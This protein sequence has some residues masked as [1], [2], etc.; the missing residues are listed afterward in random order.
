MPNERDDRVIHAKEQF[1]MSHA[2]LCTIPL[3]LSAGDAAVAAA[4]TERCVPDTHG[5]EFTHSDINACCRPDRPMLNRCSLPGL[6]DND[7]TKPELSDLH[8]VEGSSHEFDH[9]AHRLFDSDDDL[10]YNVHHHWHP[11][12]SNAHH[13]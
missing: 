11:H 10:D 6:I 12:E 7:P 9:H 5:E 3:A 13:S 4:E 2:A 1:L 8:Q